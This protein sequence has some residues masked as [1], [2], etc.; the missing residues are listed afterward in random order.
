MDFAN[1]LCQLLQMA[2]KFLLLLLAGFLALPHTI[3][4]LNGVVAEF[5]GLPF[6]GVRFSPVL[7]VTGR[8]GLVSSSCVSFRCLGCPSLKLE[9]IWLYFPRLVPTNHRRH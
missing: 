4:L 5:S 7:Q 1:W 6:V 2:T 8:A 3:D 9:P